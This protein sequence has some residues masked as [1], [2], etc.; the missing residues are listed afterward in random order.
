MAAIGEFVKGNAELP[1]KVATVFQFRLKNPDSAYVF[2]L[3][4]NPGKV[5]AG[6]VEGQAA[7]S[8]SATA[9]SS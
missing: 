8:S 3:K 1:G 7:R 2:D 4:S 6:E 5:Y 9:T